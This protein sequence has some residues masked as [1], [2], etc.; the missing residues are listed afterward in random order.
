MKHDRASKPSAPVAR[1]AGSS[2]APVVRMPEELLRSAAS[3]ASATTASRIGTARDLIRFRPRNPTQTMLRNPV[4]HIALRPLRRDG[5]GMWYQP[6]TPAAAAATANGLLTGMEPQNEGGS[7]R[8]GDVLTDAD[9]DGDVRTDGEAGAVGGVDVRTDGGGGRGRRLVRV[10]RRGRRVRTRPGKRTAWPTRPGSCARTADGEVSSV[11]TSAPA[12]VSLTGAGD[13]PENEVRA[14]AV[15]PD[16]PPE[17]PR[18]ATPSSIGRRRRRRGR[19]G[20]AD[21]A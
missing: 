19:S 16:V 14:K 3:N 5:A 7:C 8:S 2:G 9:G 15:A 17:G 6:F 12:G 10:R 1:W 20:P 4:D 18:S 13:F 11:R 21:G